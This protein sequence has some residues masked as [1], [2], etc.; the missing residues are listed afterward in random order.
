MKNCLRGLGLENSES[1]KKVKVY[2]VSEKKL[3]GEFS[4]LK[5]ASIFTGVDAWHIS[6]LLTRKGR[7]HTNKL[8]KI[9][10]FR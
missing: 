7:S 1:R 2:D 6:K 5:D 8:N 9:L 4:S 3:I 10:T